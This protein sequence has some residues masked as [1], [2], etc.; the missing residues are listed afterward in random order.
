MPRSLKALTLADH[1]FRLRLANIPPD[2]LAAAIRL[3]KKKVTPA[4]AKKVRLVLTVGNGGDAD[5]VTHDFWWKNGDEE[6]RTHA[7]ETLSQ[8]L[9]SYQ[10]DWSAAG[11]GAPGAPARTTGRCDRPGDR[12]CPAMRPAVSRGKLRP[13]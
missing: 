1:R 3:T 12:R 9:T 2:F 11:A 13:R 10:G 6:A 4:G 7:K 5:P 8:I